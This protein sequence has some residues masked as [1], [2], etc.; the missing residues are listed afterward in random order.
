MQ[1]V[2]LLHLLVM[3]LSRIF[4]WCKLVS[5]YPTKTNYIER[6]LLL[7]QLENGVILFESSSVI[8]GSDI[9]NDNKNVG[10]VRIEIVT[11]GSG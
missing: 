10:A 11:F 1:G 2:I 8:S 3:F 9:S 4:G 6:K 5:K 7:T